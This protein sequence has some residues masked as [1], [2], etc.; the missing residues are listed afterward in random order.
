MANE[1]QWRHTATGETLYATIR[2][3]TGTQ[4]NT[5]GTPAFEAVTAANWTDYD[6]ALTEGIGNYFYVGTFPA[7]SGN[8]VAGWYWVDIFK[9]AGGS[10]AITDTLQG[11]IVGYWDGTTLGPW[12][13]IARSPADTETLD[14]LAADIAAV[15]STVDGIGGGTSGSLLFEVA[16]DNVDGAIPTTPYVAATVS[17]IG[18]A[19]NTF[20]DTTA[21]GGAA[22]TIADSGGAIRYVCKFSVGAGRTATVVDLFGR[23]TVGDTVTVKAWNGVTDTWDLRKTITGSSAYVAQQIKLLSAHTETGAY[24]GQVFLLFE[25][26]TASTLYIDELLCTAA[27]LGQTIGYADGSIWVDTVSG[28]AGVT[29]FV[30]GTADNPVLT[31]ADALSL[32]ASVGIRSFRFLPGSSIQLSGD[33]TGYRFVGDVT[34]DLNGATIENC[35]FRDCYTLSGTSAGDDWTAQNCG[36]GTATLYHGYAIECRLKGTITTITGNDYFFNFCSDNATTGEATIVMAANANVYMRDYR[37]GIQITALATG[38]EFILDGAGRVLLADTCTGGTLTVRGHFPEIVG[39][40]G[41]HTAA[42]FVAHGGSFNNYAVYN[43][44]RINAEVDAALNTAIP[45]SPTADSLNE[46]VATM[47][48]TIAILQG[49]LEDV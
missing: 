36:I 20:A 17:F 44:D 3:K 40:A 1:I 10:P 14:T 37:G 26:P 5:A 32:A 7:I 25:C 28:S 12:D 43:T 9:R 2:S 13:S 35:L 34:I 4:W 45:G 18:S 48:A 29:P 8:M 46:R 24:A 41:Y 38:S 22:L 21:A 49:G 19:T 42:E 27:N 33:N 6:I 47:D 11:T 16:D 39:G 15:Q 31:W 23:I 30:N